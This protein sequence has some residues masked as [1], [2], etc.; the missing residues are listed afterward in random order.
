[1]MKDMRVEFAGK[2]SP[3]LFI[4][5]GTGTRNPIFGCMHGI[6][7]KMGWRRLFFIFYHIWW[8]FNVQ[9]CLRILWII[10]IH[11]KHLTKNEENPC[12]TCLQS[13]SLRGT[14]KPPY[15]FRHYHLLQIF[16]RF[17]KIVSS[18]VW[19]IQKK[20]INSVNRKLNRILVNR[21]YHYDHYNIYTYITQIQVSLQI[22]LRRIFPIIFFQKCLIKYTFLGVIFF[23]ILT[24]GAVGHI[25]AISIYFSNV[26]QTPAT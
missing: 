23:S 5:S 4:S 21:V 2:I 3:R 12:T 16:W 11:G 14:R 10:I 1:M 18:C 25:C 6:S 7:R 8:F 9:K 13:I 19:F 20:N 17:L 22:C 15:P 26:S 24:Q